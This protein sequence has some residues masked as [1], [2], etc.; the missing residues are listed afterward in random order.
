MVGA[1]ARTLEAL[2]EHL[3]STVKQLTTETV[4]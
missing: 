3:D 2:K 1:G 4:A